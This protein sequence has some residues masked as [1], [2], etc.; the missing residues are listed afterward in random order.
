M[1]MSSKHPVVGV[2]G[3]LF[4]TCVAVSAQTSA[5]SDRWRGMILDQS[6]PDD[7]MKGFGNPK[8]DSSGNIYSW[9]IQNW[10]SARY[11]YTR[12]EKSFRNLEY[13][14]VDKNIKKAIF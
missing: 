6:L 4:L 1:R 14:K 11:K 8:K 7:V 5:Q 9:P 10:L 13:E 3:I 12:G 2:A